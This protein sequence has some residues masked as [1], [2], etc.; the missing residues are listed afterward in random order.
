MVKRSSQSNHSLRMTQASQPVSAVRHLALSCWC[1]QGST[2][3]AQKQL[4]PG[5]CRAQVDPYVI[6]SIKENRKQRTK[7]IHNNNHPKWNE[8]ITTIVN[9]PDTQS[10]TFTLMDDDV[11]SFD[12]VRCP[13]VVHCAAD[14]TSMAARAC[15]AIAL[16]PCIS[17]SELSALAWW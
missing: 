12:S 14:I 9:D 5:S 10:I 6:V 2:P 15:T 16:L 13:F 11:G 8:T 4:K 7:T 17:C 3:A 1:V